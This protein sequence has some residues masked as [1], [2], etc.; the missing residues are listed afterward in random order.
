[1]SFVDKLKSRLRYQTEISTPAYTITQTIPFPIYELDLKGL[2]DADSI[3]EKCLSI[4]TKKNHKPNTVINGW[5]SQYYSPGSN[6]FELFSE[7]INIIEGKLNLITSIRKSNTKYKIID[8]WIVIYGKDTYHDWHNHTR[9]IDFT[10]Y[11]GVYYPVASDNAEPIEFKNNDST[12]SITA[13]KDKLLIFP[14]VLTHRVPKCNDS[15]LRI[16]ISFNS[17]N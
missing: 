15:E 13:K 3:K 8:F 6:E 5:Q 10:G 1:M 2:I 11:S 9:F 17:V 4:K 12:F 7:F 14:S 16:A